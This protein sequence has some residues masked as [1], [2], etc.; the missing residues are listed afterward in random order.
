MQSTALAEQ[1]HRQDQQTDQWR[2]YR[3][4]HGRGDFLPAEMRRTHIDRDQPVFMLIGSQDTRQCLEDIVLLAAFIRK[5]LHHAACTVA[6]SLRLRAI[7]IDDL[8]IMIGTGDLG[9]MNGHDL[10]KRGWLISSQTDCSGRCDTIAASA[11]IGNNDLVA[12]SV[13]LGEDSL[14]H[15]WFGVPLCWKAL[16]R[17]SI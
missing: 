2:V 10:V 7:A 1:A 5:P 3:Q 16:E 11:H 14:A 15:C 12:Q 6:A 4:L 9:I 17:V 8:D 13:H